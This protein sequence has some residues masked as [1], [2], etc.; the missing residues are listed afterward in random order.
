MAAWAE[1]P[2]GQIGSESGIYPSKLRRLNGVWE[3][4]G[5]AVRRAPGARRRRWTAIALDWGGGELWR[6]AVRDCR[7][8]VWN[9][10]HCHK[11][12]IVVR[13]FAADSC[14]RQGVSGEGDVTRADFLR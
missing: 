7:M 11:R 8:T 9:E 13:R 6:G 12:A 10:W 5:R 3:Q 2:L 1:V 14:V 4:R